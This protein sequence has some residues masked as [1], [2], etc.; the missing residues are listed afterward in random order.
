MQGVLE[1]EQVVLRLQVAVAGA[2]QVVELAGQV[3]TQSLLP[4]LLQQPADVARQ[5]PGK[6]TLFLPAG[7]KQV[8][9]CG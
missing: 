1:P 9:L 8:V 7:Q 3:C 6:A 2:P 5:R 4:A